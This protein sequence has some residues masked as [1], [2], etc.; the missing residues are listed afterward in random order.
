MDLGSA[1]PSLLNTEVP[2][3]LTDREHLEREWWE[4]SEGISSVPD[5][6]SNSVSVGK[7]LASLACQLL[8][9]PLQFPSQLRAYFLH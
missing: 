3:L 9:T 2:C 5:H 7:G 6:L 1:F 4:L 8:K